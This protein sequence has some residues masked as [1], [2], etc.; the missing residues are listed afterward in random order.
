MKSL[1]LLATLLALPAG[2]H[3]LE[4]FVLALDGSLV[5]GATVEAFLPRGSEDRS[6]RT[7]IASVKTKDGRFA[8]EKLPA[9]VVQIEASAQDGGSATALVTPY[10]AQVNLVLRPAPSRDDETRA[11]SPLM[12][13]GGGTISGVVRVGAGTLAGV[14]VVVQ[15]LGIDGVRPLRVVTDAKGRYEARGLRPMRYAVTTGD[16]LWPRLRPDGFGRMYS[17]GSEPNIA[18]LQSASSATVDLTL[19]V[20]PTI[21][22]RV[23][24]AA[25]K[26]VANAQVQVVLAGRSLLDFANEPFARTSPDGRYS[27]PAPPF[28]PAELAQVAVARRST[29][30][31]RSKPFT[32]GDGD[33]R[34]DVT[35]PPLHAVT[36][37]VA[38][39]DGKPL[40]GARVTF[41]ESAEISS[42]RNPA[43]LLLPMFGSR[44]SRTDANGEIGLELAAGSYD[45][46][47]SAEG[48]QVGT[49][50]ER[51]ITRAGRV[52][53][54]L[55]R[56]VAIRGRVHRAGQGVSNVRV[57]LGGLDRTRAD[58]PVATGADGSFEIAGLAR[59]TYAVQ[60]SKHEELVD[61]T[62]EAEAP[63]TLDV[64]LPPAGSLRVRVLDA[65][66][67]EP[68][69]Q[70]FYTI[71]PLDEER[72]AKDAP[73]RGRRPE[74]MMARGEAR[75]DGTV[76]ATLSAG[77]YRLTA[78]AT[79]F[80]TSE[81]LEVLVRAGEITES[82][83]LLERGITVTGRVTDDAGSPLANASVFVTNVGDETDARRISSRIAPGSAETGADGTFRISGL[84]PGSVHVMVRRDGFVAHRSTH[85]TDTLTTLDVKLE[86][87]LTLRGI[88][89][90]DGKPLARVEVG[91]TTAATGGDHQSARTD[92]NGRFELRGL[93][94]A[95]YT[96]HAFHEDRNREIR[97]VDPAQQRE[98]V[99][100]LD[101]QPRG[102]I[103]GN[104]T[105][106]PAT[107]GKHGR[108]AVYVQSDD[109]GVEGAI[110]EQGNY[111]IEDAPVG[112][113]WVAAQVE[114]S[115]AMRSSARRRIDVVAGQAVRVDL[116][117]SPAA[118]V[119]GRVTLDGKPV[120]N[121]R[122]L[123]LS[124]E[125]SMGASAS[126]R[127]DGGYEIAL[128]STGTYRIFTHVEGADMRHFETVREIRGGETIDLAI[129]EQVIEGIV[130]DAATRAPVDRAVVTLASDSNL[131]SLAGEVITDAS[132]RFRMP[133]AAHGAYRLIVSAPEYAHRIER[134]TLGG[135]DPAP[136]A[137]DLEKAHPLRVRVVDAKNQTT[138]EA[139][140]TI[141][142]LQ[143]AP[144]PVRSQR[145]PDG[146]FHTFSL[147][148]GRYRLTSV[149]HGY[150]TRTMEVTAPGMI[151]VRM[152]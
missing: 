119:R 93:I 68:V 124:D 31:A 83:I 77:R 112:S 22:G 63:A 34:V 9:A 28:A 104:V 66:T 81:P 84:E 125:E 147:A 47:G 101:P 40:S 32:L 113:V 148:P 82:D 42:V 29:S 37:R 48:F 67:R 121:A 151:D 71:T 114:S 11:T 38:G 138:L 7:A 110:D 120:P 18:D 142:T 15:G 12:E 134:I 62:V 5:D 24:D 20:A 21:S 105:G 150:T 55:D 97:D 19:T 76:A 135:A 107:G 136:V 53:L 149:V 64:E 1:L 30:T 69:P 152:E 2:A 61:R 43:M 98:L 106:I 111:R 122:I 80:T 90:R 123:F 129:R 33:R 27:L 137:I 87:G 26:A 52:E 54:V 79:G 88:V 57:M 95:R 3:D 99:I 94:R 108:R 141:E 17:E 23:V 16:G 74:R 36:V 132:G 144:L 103:F 6:P 117:L 72:S 133:T 109:R 143:G 131:A 56:A 145:S 100:D 46:V 45:F 49:L 128:T 102:T 73:S 44:I 85:A 115:G 58:A 140:V 8:F 39:G 25:G 92:E 127:A 118:V 146:T 116:D 50:Q 4:G 51:S 35:L 59:G 10:D 130:L 65:A 70:I 41:A 96:V 91:A 86:R 78:Q 89:R 139:H 126:S 75:A 14:P 13:R 60:F